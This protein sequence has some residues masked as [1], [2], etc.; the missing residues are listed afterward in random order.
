MTATAPPTAL[1]A[2]SATIRAAVEDYLHPHFEYLGKAPYEL[3][4]LI[5]AELEAEGWE[6]TRR[7][8]AGTVSR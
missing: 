2:V 4:E 7:L 5:L 1:P 8:A 6:I 3:T